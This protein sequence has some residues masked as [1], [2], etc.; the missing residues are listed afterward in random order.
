M[1]NRNSPDYGKKIDLTPD[2]VFRDPY[3][4]DFLGLR[5]TYSEKDLEMAILRELEGF[6]LE[7]RIGFTFAARQKRITVDEVDS[8]LDLLFTIGN[9]GGWLLSI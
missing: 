6:I 3:F 8:Y 2:L 4:L 9:S 1:R 7:L 5:D